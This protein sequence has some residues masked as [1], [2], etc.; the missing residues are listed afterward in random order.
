MS[1]AETPPTPG[2]PVA[3]TARIGR[4]FR[5]IREKVPIEPDWLI[6]GVLCR[7][8]VAMVAGREKV[9]KGTLIW[10]LLA[11][12]AVG[13]AG[14]LGGETS[15]E[16]V[17]ALVYTE[18]PDHSIAEKARQAGE[19]LDDCQCITHWEMAAALE[20]ELAARA[21]F[22]AA[23]G[24]GALPELRESRWETFVNKL[25]EQAVAGGHGV[26]YLDNIS[27]AAGV[28]DEAGVELAAAIKPLSDAAKRY[29][30]GVVVDHHHR[31]A[32]GRTEDKSRGGTATAGAVESIMDIERVGDAT[33][34]VRKLTA[35]GR[36]SSNNWTRNVELSADGRRYVAV[37]STSR[38][39]ATDAEI[40]ELLKELGEATAMELAKARGH[41]D[42]KRTR[43]W[44][45]DHA[46]SLV[47]NA[48][49][50]GRAQ[51]YRVGRAGEP[52]KF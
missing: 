17:T 22:R 28:T 15:G 45:R 24:D 40:V 30:V 21:R 47:E 46:D 32:A 16:P 6:P 34:R 44:L 29:G 8:W 4:T 39:D 12:L 41:A 38:E 11:A 43:A 2:Q 48:G 9:G 42:D 25:V 7:G 52:P 31:K 20:R 3:P 51:L 50:R 26:I 37:Q 33:S 35:R 36:L 49:K 1:V 18:E 13:E 19:R 10:H 23:M 27:R 14:V 5:E